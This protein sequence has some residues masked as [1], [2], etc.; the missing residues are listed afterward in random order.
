MTQSPTL[1][2]LFDATSQTAVCT[3][4]KSDSKTSAQLLFEAESL[5]GQPLNIDSLI[6]ILETGIVSCTGI[7]FNAT[8]SSIGK[9][10]E[11]SNIRVH[12]N[13]LVVHPHSSD[14]QFDVLFFR[15]CAKMVAHIADALVEHKL[16]ALND[17]INYLQQ[18]SRRHQ[19]DLCFL[20]KIKED[21]SNFRPIE[22]KLQNEKSMLTALGLAHPYDFDFLCEIRKLFEVALASESVALTKKRGAFPCFSSSGDIYNDFSF[23]LRNEAPNIFDEMIMYGR[24]NQFIL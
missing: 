15:K 3:P 17:K 9:F 22:I 11:H 1:F 8:A 6:D 18:S 2:D 24:R 16:M 21:T 14:A 4:G 10:T 20:Q 19:R 5:I 7:Y 12:L 23:R 13:K